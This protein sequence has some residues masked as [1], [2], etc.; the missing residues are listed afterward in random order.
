MLSLT[1]N[2]GKKKRWVIM[3]INMFLMMKLYIG[4]NDTDLHSRL[5]CHGRP[6]DNIPKEG[7]DEINNSDVFYCILANSNMSDVVESELISRYKPKYNKVKKHLWSGL[8]YIEPIWIKYESNKN[9]KELEELIFTL[10]NE[11][12]FWKNQIE[13]YKERLHEQEE[14]TYSFHEIYEWYKKEDSISGVFKAIAYNEK[15]SF[16][17]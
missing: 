7:W 9:K 6:G 4:K 16:L 12:S 1:D 14:K 3:Y 2:R 13:Q 8:N 5:K 15:T 17:L 11:N 10:K